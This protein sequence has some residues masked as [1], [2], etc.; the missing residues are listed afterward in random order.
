MK[1]AVPVIIVMLCAAGFFAYVLN[2][3]R[4][5]PPEEVGSKP[6][7]T[8][9]TAFESTPVSSPVKAVQEP[10]WTPQLSTL[11]QQFLEQLSRGNPKEARDLSRKLIKEA[12][13]AEKGLMSAYINARYA[14]RAETLLKE[15]HAPSS[16]ALSAAEA[17]MLL[18]E[19]RTTTDAARQLEIQGKLVRARLPEEVL[20][21][22]QQFIATE[23]ARRKD[24]AAALSLLN[25]FVGNASAQA[26]FGYLETSVEKTVRLAAADLIGARQLSEDDRGRIKRQYDAEGN[27]DVRASLLLSLIKSFT[28]ASNEV[29]R[30]ALTDSSERVRA[31]AT[32]GLNPADE[33]D[34]TTLLDLMGRESSVM[35][36]ER[37][38]AQLIKEP[39]NPK[40][41]Q[42]I[43]NVASTD[44]SHELRLQA[45]R[46]LADPD[47][48]KHAG[49]PEALRVIAQNDASEEVRTKALA[50]L[51]SNR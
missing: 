29:A 45:V 25:S 1:R 49:V 42:A 2:S 50:A 48:Y 15:A 33:K 31:V 43:L 39:D 17:R 4:S 51:Q 21:D 11:R 10:S 34:R 30:S 41:A 20:S 3:D 22:V 7:E 32:F 40:V 16:V 9:K 23:I 18:E 26:L 24:P 35:V 12:P 6:P 36:R 38:L 19:Y 44:D 14:D 5:H 46:A 27:G 13:D 28:P 47:L 37:A 8:P